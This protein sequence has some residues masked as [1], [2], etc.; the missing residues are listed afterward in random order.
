[1]WKPNTQGLFE[2]VFFR[3]ILGFVCL[4]EQGK[5][6]QG[7]FDESL[8]VRKASMNS[9]DMPGCS[10]SYMINTPVQLLKNEGPQC[11]RILDMFLSSPSVWEGQ[12]NAHG[13]SAPEGKIEK[14]ETQPYI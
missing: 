5:Q 7:F 1:M 12:P 10:A 13:I 14:F 8:Q 11:W 9:W 4:E 6:S 2:E 3:K